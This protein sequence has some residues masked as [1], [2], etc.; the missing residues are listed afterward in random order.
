MRKWELECNEQ[1]DMQHALRIL[2][3]GYFQKRSVVP[4][5]FKYMKTI[6]YSL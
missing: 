1:Y 2:N 3:S 4:N 5:K 6:C